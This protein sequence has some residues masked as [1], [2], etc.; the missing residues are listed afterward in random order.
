[1]NRMTSV[2]GT[3]QVPIQVAVERAGGAARFPQ[4][5]LLLKS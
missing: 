4:K 3:I 5:I 2:N 1:M